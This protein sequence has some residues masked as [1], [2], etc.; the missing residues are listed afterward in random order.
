MCW[1]ESLP[2]VD[3]HPLALGQVAGGG[4]SRFG[5]HTVRWH[6][7]SLRQNYPALHDISTRYELADESLPPQ[8]P[9]TG[10]SFKKAATFPLILVLVGSS[11]RRR[12]PAARQGTGGEPAGSEDVNPNG[13]RGERYPRSS[14]KLLLHHLQ[15]CQASVMG[16]ALVLCKSQPIGIAK[17]G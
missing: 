2:P 14:G 11:A 8:E 1:P 9:P 4:K 13:M 7:D 10:S 17:S 3:G 12:S 16:K 15:D 5:R 6:G